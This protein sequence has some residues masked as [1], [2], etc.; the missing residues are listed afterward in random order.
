MTFSHTTGQN[1]FR[2]M[3]IR[4]NNLTSGIKT[5]RRRFYNGAYFIEKILYYISRVGLI[6]SVLLKV[7][8]PLAQKYTPTGRGC[9]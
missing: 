7:T 4:R 2:R 5:T 9:L 6:Q 1:K 8:L 3:A